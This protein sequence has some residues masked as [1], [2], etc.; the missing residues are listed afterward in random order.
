[1]ER[2]D[3]EI[4]QEWCKNT[5]HGGENTLREETERGK[6]SGSHGCEF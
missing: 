3:R 4:R 5:K 6:I 2:D 1:V